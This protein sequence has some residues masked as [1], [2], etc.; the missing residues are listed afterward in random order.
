MG[1]PGTEG[2]S[3]LSKVTILGRDRASVEPRSPDFSLI[4]F[5]L[6]SPIA[7]LGLFLLPV[8]ET[9]LRLA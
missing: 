4:L 2:R 8:I 7:C 5:S 1:K 9:K 3:D 6:D